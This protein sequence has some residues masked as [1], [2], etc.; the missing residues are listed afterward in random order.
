[1]TDAH[2]LTPL[3]AVRSV[4]VFGAS[5][6]PKRISGPALAHCLARRQRCDLRRPFPSARRYETAGV[7]ISRTPGAQPRPSPPQLAR[8]LSRLSR[9]AAAWRGQASTST[10]S[11]FARASARA[12]ALDALFLTPNDAAS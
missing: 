5:N 4:A 1:M 6:D 9:I 11:W 10:R 2:P 7:A 8:A 12:A 3:V